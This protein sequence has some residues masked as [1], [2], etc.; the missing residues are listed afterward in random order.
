MLV[1]LHPRYIVSLTFLLASILLWQPQAWSAPRSGE[2]ATVILPV[3]YVRGHKMVRL[4]RMFVPVKELRHTSI[5]YSPMLHKILV[6]AKPD[7]IQR[8]SAASKQI[9]V[10][11]TQFLV[12]VY[13]VKSSPQAEKQVNQ[14]KALIDFLKK[15]GAP[16]Q[17]HSVAE[18]VFVRTT[19]H[20]E[21]NLKVT[22]K[23]TVA[24][25][26]L[27]IVLHQPPNPKENILVKLHI[28]H[29]EEFRSTNRNGTNTQFI[30][31]T[32]LQ[33]RLFIKPNQ[34]ALV[35]STSLRRSKGDAQTLVVIKVKRL[36]DQKAKLQS[37]L[38]KLDKKNIRKVIQ[39]NQAKF[40]RCY[41]ASLQKEPN[42]KGRV[43]VSFSIQP[44]GKVLSPYI[45][46]S[47]L[48]HLKTELCLLKIFH[49]MK[50]PAPAQGGT[51]R[52]NYPLVFNSK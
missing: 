4:L 49:V 26:S 23:S 12:Q 28:S 27:Q 43:I 52:V 46:K 48:K 41:A 34:F 11:Q 3:R 40:Q 44:S 19:N 9:D 6:R 15:S 45:K 21:T 51:V 16:G 50:F 35:G 1:S 42:I 25:P 17:N 37:P 38:T 7:I 39:A 24:D 18:H 10:P 31:A 8:I 14:P 5:R 32:Q 13:F 30:K 36:G 20:Y 33:T 29:H 22:K 2:S 47:T